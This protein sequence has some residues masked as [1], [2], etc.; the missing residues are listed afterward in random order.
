MGFRPAV[1][2]VNPVKALR[3]LL[4][5]KTQ[6]SG[7]QGEGKEVA[8][9]TAFFELYWGE[10]RDISR[11]EGV[12]EAA[13]RAGRDPAAVAEAVNDPGAKAQLQANTD[14]LIARRGFGSPS[15]FIGGDRFSGHHSLK[16]VRHAQQR[17]DTATRT[18]S[19][20]P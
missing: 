10:D 9:A 3:G 7:A 16:L 8:L 19:H 12:A 6:E 18:S 17:Q 1:F 20:G 4:W 5:A 13:G 11:D 14:E 15:S 2:P